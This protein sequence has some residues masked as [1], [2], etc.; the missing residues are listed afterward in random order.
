MTAIMDIE[1]AIKASRKNR[2]T[3]SFRLILLSLLAMLALSANA[4][5]KENGDRE[6]QKVI[7]SRLSRITR[8]C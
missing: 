6:Y 3:K 2:K 8:K 1:Q 4:V 5:T 7:I